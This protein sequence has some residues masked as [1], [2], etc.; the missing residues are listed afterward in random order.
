MDERDAD[1]RNAEEGLAERAN[2]NGADA[3]EEDGKEL[4]K[5]AGADVDGADAVEE[6][7]NGLI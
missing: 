6:D 5:R 1:K 3:A 7:A 4:R 2:M